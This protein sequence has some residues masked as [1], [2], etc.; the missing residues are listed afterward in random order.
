MMK[1]YLKITMIVLGIIIILMIMWNNLGIKATEYY[2]FPEI[3]KA[4][5]Y[6]LYYTPSWVFNVFTIIEVCIIALYIKYLLS[7]RVD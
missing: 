4:Y 3:V 7:Y 1:K 6:Y 2:I 5:Q